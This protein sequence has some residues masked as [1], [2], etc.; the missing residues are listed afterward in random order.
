MHAFL[1]TLRCPDVLHT[2]HLSLTGGKYEV[3]DVS[4]FHDMYARH[5][6][7]HPGVHLVEKVR[8]PSKWYLDVDHVD[9]KRI[10]AVVGILLAHGE[11]CVVC[12]PPNSMDG[13]HV[14]FTNVRV[15]SK[16]DACARSETLLRNTSIV[17]DKSV[18]SS[19]LRMIGSKK[20]KGNAPRVYMPFY[21]VLKRY[22]GERL[23]PRTITPS[24]LSE[25]SI[26]HPHAA[27]PLRSVP[28]PVV[29]TTIRHLS[30]GTNMIDLSFIHPMYARIEPTSIKRWGTHNR[31][32]I[33]TN[34]RFCMH[35]N[36]E[37]KSAGV[38]FE[39]VDNPV[40]TGKPKTIRCR[41]TCK[42]AHT[43]CD[44]FRGIAHA[45]PMKLLH[46]IYTILTPRGDPPHVV[47]DPGDSSFL[48]HLF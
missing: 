7:Q 20:G 2:T 35:L 11:P 27:D 19:G 6:A 31:S 46:A 9:D 4:G 17:F 16:Q 25:C 28:T 34:Q 15:D 37:H 40:I 24:L 41:C 29:C 21:R 38:C 18:Y 10:N 39:I 36:K 13:I 43:G 30:M 26:H 1:S 42:C 3:K 45:L 14:I 8:Y 22:T 5:Y 48:D 47:V 44:A 12:V 23:C 33:F 32:Y